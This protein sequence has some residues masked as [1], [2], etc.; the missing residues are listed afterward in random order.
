MN[1]PGTGAGDAL[2]DA[3][4]ISANILPAP[5]DFSMAWNPKGNSGDAAR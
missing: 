4:H 1:A 5:R 2:F 3:L